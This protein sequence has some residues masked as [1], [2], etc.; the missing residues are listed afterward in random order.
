M[1]FALFSGGLK[2]LSM[3][4]L[5]TYTFFALLLWHLL[6]TRA[7]YKVEFFKKD[8]IRSPII[9]SQNIVSDG[10]KLYSSVNNHEE[11]MIYTGVHLKKNTNYLIEFDLK[12][13]G[14][15][16]KDFF[17]IYD[18]IAP[19]WDEVYTFNIKS[20]ITHQACNCI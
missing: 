6:A 8:I 19:G 5:I 3:K 1:R 4:K 20:L 11:K 14:K 9:T 12:V 16:K 10:K 17:L 18:F 15:N 7:L 2:M 13:H